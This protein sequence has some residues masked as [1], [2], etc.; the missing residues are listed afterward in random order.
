MSAGQVQSHSWLVNNKTKN[1]QEGCYS[2]KI[3]ITRFLGII[4]PKEQGTK[5]EK[6]SEGP[7]TTDIDGRGHQENARD[8]RAD[9]GEAEENER[10]HAR[11]RAAIVP[12]ITPSSRAKRQ[13]GSDPRDR[14]STRLNSSHV[15]ISY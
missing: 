3:R 10:N 8:Q 11:F 9:D 5:G 14:K 15:S 1:R 12:T 6:Y 2:E 4:E 7:A 13:S